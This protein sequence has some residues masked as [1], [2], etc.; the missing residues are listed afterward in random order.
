[1]KIR[2]MVDKQ[3]R[4]ADIIKSWL[5][6]DKHGILANQDH[7]K[8]LE[9]LDKLL[10]KLEKEYDNYPGAFLYL[11]VLRQIEFPITGAGYASSFMPNGLLYPQHPEYWFTLWI[12]GVITD[13]HIYWPRVSNEKQIIIGR[14]EVIED[15]VI[16]DENAW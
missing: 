7:S 12:N 3:M 11:D 16:E 1:M 6:N 10:P 2:V 13:L 8:L 9:R 14:V 5:E 15:M 4:A